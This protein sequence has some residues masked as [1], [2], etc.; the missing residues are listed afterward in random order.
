MRQWWRGPG[1]AAALVGAGVL[2]LV[3]VG[4]VGAWR[5]AP[6]PTTPPVGTSAA[7][8]GTLPPTT[9]L[10][11]VGRPV[12]NSIGARQL[13]L[14]AG[15][16]WVAAEASNQVVRVDPASGLATGVI[17]VR[18]P[19]GIAAGYGAIWVTSF[20]EHPA[21]LRID[22]VRLRVTARTSI[23]DI[24]AT[25]AAGAGAV[26]VVCGEGN[27]P[28]VQRVDPA[29][30]H[31]T[32][33]IGLAS[34][35]VTG[36]GLWNVAAEGRWVWVSDEAGSLWRI[37]TADNRAHKLPVSLSGPS[38]WAQPGS[39]V[40]ASGMV[41]AASD[42]ELLRLDPA[43]GRVVVRLD[44]GGRDGKGATGGSG[45]AAVTVVPGRPGT[46]WWASSAGLRRVDPHR[47]QV[48]VTIPKPYPAGS[49]VIQGG[50]VAGT[51]GLWAITD[52]GVVRIDPAR[53]P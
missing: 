52:Q 44:A 38:S 49:T 21:L 35:V 6:Q 34:R 53:A 39:V 2:V 3:V 18:Q 43:S 22:P 23:G 9:V 40:A 24:A 16:L 45:R 4:R 51:S 8:A 1:R 7:T 30:G 29:T 33:R 41:W 10:A 37:G 17:P 50:L 5:P 12:D 19:L 14:G 11:V 42:L 36:C 15:S 13:A 32:A 31:V 25:V 20:G 28:S 27:G 48:T 26:W 46:V 47:N